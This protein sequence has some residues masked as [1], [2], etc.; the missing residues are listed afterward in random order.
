MQQ[1]E[2]RRRRSSDHAEALAMLLESCR[3]RTGLDALVIS[4]HDGLLLS[5]STRPGKDVDPVTIAAHLPRT[6]WRSLIPSL[7]ARTFKLHG[8]RMFLGAVGNLSEQMVNDL[9]NAMR[10]TQRILT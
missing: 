4:D 5:W 10:G 9:L 6:Q 8:M 2:R 3:E 7:Y 1:Q